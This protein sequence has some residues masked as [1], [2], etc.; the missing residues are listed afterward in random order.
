M[1]DNLKKKLNDYSQIQ[2]FFL[3]ESLCFFFVTYYIKKLEISNLHISLRKSILFFYLPFKSIL[4]KNQY[5]KM[6]FFCIH[7][8]RHH[9]L[10]DKIC[11]ISLLQNKEVFKISYFFLFHAPPP[12]FACICSTWFKKKTS[13]ALFIQKKSPFYRKRFV[14]FKFFNTILIFCKSFKN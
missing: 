7:F 1:L 13:V 10:F 14:K 5:P 4:L 2:L 6:V 9:R 11:N 12:F 3:T 8:F